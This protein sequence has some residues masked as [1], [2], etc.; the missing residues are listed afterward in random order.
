MVSLKDVTRGKPGSYSFSVSYSLPAV[1]E[2]TGNGM[3]LSLELLS[4]FP[5]PVKDLHVLVQLPGDV[6]GTP[7]FSSGYHQQSVRD[8]L[9]VTVELFMSLEVT[10]V[11]AKI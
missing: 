6:T 10:S 9:E 3:D 11:S 1:V 5:Y 4:G 7:V 8:L 2:S